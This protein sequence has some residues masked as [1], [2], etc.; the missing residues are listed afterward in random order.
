MHKRRCIVTHPL[1]ALGVAGWLLAAGGVFAGSLQ[2][3]H[4]AANAVVRGTVPLAAQVTGIQGVA[5]VEFLLNGHVLEAGPISEPPY[6][7]EWNSAEVWNGEMQLTAVARDS[8]GRILATAAPVPFEV[9]N[10]PARMRHLLPASPGPVS[11]RVEW[12]V[13]V[14]GVEPTEAVMFLVDGH[15]VRIIFGGQQRVSVLLDTTEFANGPHELFAAAHSLTE[16]KRPLAMSQVR[17]TFDNGRT[18]RAVLPRYRELFLAP[19]ETKAL[20]ARLL[21]TNADREPAAGVHY[22]SLDPAVASVSA[23]GVVR[24]VGAGVTTVVVEAQQRRAEVAVVVGDP[25][26][27]P[28]FSREGRFLVSYKPGQSLFVRTLFTLDHQELE[29]T[30]ELAARLQAADIN[31]V[32]SAFWSLPQDMGHPK[33]FE[34][35]RQHWDPM[36]ERIESVA[37]KHDFR[38]LLTGDNVARGPA[39]LATVLSASWGLPGLW[40]AFARMRDSGRVVG[41][42]M[43]DEASGLWGNVALPD[44]GR[45]LQ[46]EPPIPDDA[47]LRIMDVIRSVPNASPVTWPVLWLSPPEAIRN[48]MGDPLLSDYTSMF[49]DKLAWRQAYPWGIS[50]PQLRESMEHVTVK[51][52]HLI[53]RD[54]PLLLQMSVT[55]PFYTKLGPGNSYIPGQDRLQAAGHTPVNV[56]AQALYAMAVGA[57]GVRVY[58]YELET[59]PGFQRY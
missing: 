56:A 36:W 26:G 16:P 7:L 30:P 45:W 18:I 33:D 59:Q 19:G 6:A 25:P 8:T 37:R 2:V 14:S 15:Q 38:L 1:L 41:V 58:S 20:A 57:A 28:H 53:Q 17:V 39:E 10:G 29:R 24:A 22:E 23:D 43:V 48:W 9:V 46:R 50:L 27:V 4:P 13:E 34:Q 49:W 31:T 55:G 3:I 54:R 44:D 40:H 21:Y 12:T 11:G 5:S 47:F 51:R 32:T 35:W 42:E 52:R